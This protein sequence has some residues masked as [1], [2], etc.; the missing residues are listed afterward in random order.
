MMSN[1]QS[2]VL[3]GIKIHLNL[4]KISIIKNYKDI[5]KIYFLNVIPKNLKEL[6]KLHKN[7]D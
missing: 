3:R 4:I 5:E 7:E 6:R 1:L 2:M